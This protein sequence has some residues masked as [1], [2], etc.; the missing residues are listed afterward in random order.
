MGP[1]CTLDL[2]SAA[3][4]SEAVLRVSQQRVCLPLAGFVGVSEAASESPGSCLELT[5]DV[6]GAPGAHSAV[7]P[8]RLRCHSE[9]DWPSVWKEIV[10]E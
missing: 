7:H 2:V 1:Q 5:L 4:A 8:M 6:L 3:G 10:K 9:V